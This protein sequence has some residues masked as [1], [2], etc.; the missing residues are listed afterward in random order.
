M[1]NEENDKCGSYG[2]ME[3][4][5]IDM[6]DDTDPLVKLGEKNRDCIP[7]GTTLFGLHTQPGITMTNLIAIPYI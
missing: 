3:G 5:E 2:Q 6:Q 1:N 7:E 4:D